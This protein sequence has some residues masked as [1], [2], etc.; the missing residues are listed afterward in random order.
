MLRGLSLGLLAGFLLS[1]WPSGG[2]AWLPAVLYTLAIAADY[3][4]GYL[5]RIT[6]H[7]TVLGETLDVE[8]DALGILIVT[9]LAVHYK[10]LPSWYL[11]LGL[12]RYLFIFGIWRRKRCNRP[13]YDLPPSTHRRIIAGFQMGFSS[14]MLW[15]IVYPPATTLAGV[16]FAIP[17]AASFTRDWLVVSGRLDPI[18]P[19]YFEARRKVAV[20][21][22]GWLPVLLRIGA[23][24]LAAWF[25][26]FPLWSV[27]DRVELLAWPGVPF[28]RLT[29]MTLS[30]VA[31]VAT[32][33]LAL[34]AAG[35]LAAFGLLIVAS[36][37]ILAS[38][39]YVYNGLLLL[40]S[41]ALMLLGSGYFSCWRPED[42]F[43]SRRAGENKETAGP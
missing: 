8:F 6:N 15:P 38:G 39:L 4:D 35:R 17:F 33:M 21:I 36:A 31:L 12:S 29:A 1:P 5:A 25:V 18:S 16:V 24:A 34:G 2:L 23:V 14:V 37:N 20:A 9:S 30:L 40:S 11:L 26:L 22:A 28:P 43:L 42:A 27:P 3:L 41:V 7:A 32:P 13:V 19:V 10:Q